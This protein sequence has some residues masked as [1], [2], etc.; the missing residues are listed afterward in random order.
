MEYVTSVFFALSDPLR[1]RSLA[2]LAAQ[3]ELCVCELT[4]ALQASQ[5]TVSKHMATLRDAGLVRDR[6]DAQW[7]LYSLASEL[8]AWVK[9][10][11]AGAVKGVSAEAV[12][13][14]D[15]KRLRAMAARPSRNRAA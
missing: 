6:R 11:L 12:H 2:L 7:V 13:R 14:D 4:H 1:L 9:D 5:P 8:P 10:V 15:G 3:G